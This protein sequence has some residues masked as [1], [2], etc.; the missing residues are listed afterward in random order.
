MQL[1][2][3]H[4]SINWK[5]LILIVVILVVLAAGLL[6]LSFY[7]KSHT[8]PIYHNSKY[9]YSFNYPRNWVID[10]SN[11]EKDFAQGVGGQLVMSNYENGA[12]QLESKN[13]PADLMAIKIDVYKVSASATLGAIVK[14]KANSF[15]RAKTNFLI[16]PVS[17]SGLNAKQ[18]IYNEPDAQNN[19]VT[20]KTVFKHDTNMFVFTCNYIRQDLTKENKYKLP[21]AAASA[22][23]GVLNSFKLK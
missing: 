8:S 1:E 13:A 23:N 12:A 19:L 2:I 16:Q 7:Q 6:G 18:F 5:L 17:L 22:Y 21:D 15:M 10:A 11:A 14:S 20:V 4:I 9:N 3:R